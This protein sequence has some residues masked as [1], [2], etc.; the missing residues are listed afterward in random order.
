MRTR[1][2][3]GSQGQNAI[4][5]KLIRSD[6]TFYLDSERYSV[7]YKDSLLQYL[8][9]YFTVI[10]CPADIM[11]TFAK[12]EKGG[13]HLWL[14]FRT[15]FNFLEATGYDTDALNVYRKALPTFQCGIDLNVPEEAAML[16]ALNKVASAKAEYNALF[17]LL[18]DS[19]LRLIEAV[20]AMGKIESAEPINGFY[21]IALGEFRGSK[22]AYFAYF[23]EATY[24]QLLTVKAKILDDRHSTSYY[25]RHKIIRPKHV[26]KFAFDTMIGLEIPESVAD[27]IQGRV[28]RSIGA[29]HYTALKRQ[30]DKFYGKYANYLTKLRLKC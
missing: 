11:R 18:V 9:K 23:T 26:R 24:N 30:S 7:G 12:V 4:T 22:Q 15:V 20:K 5:W 2:S 8:D 21:R 17:N 1:R 27:F 10:N 28:A 25:C 13:R 19:G 3:T 16:Q 6:F 14:G 29:R